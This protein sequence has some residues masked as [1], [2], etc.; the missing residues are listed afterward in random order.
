MACTNALLDASA[1]PWLHGECKGQLLPLH[2]G[3]RLG[4]VSLVKVLLDRCPDLLEAKTALELRPLHYAAEAK[5]HRFEIATLLVEKGADV[6]ASTA[7]GNLPSHYAGAMMDSDV[8]VKEV[9]AMYNLLN[10]HEDRRNRAGWTAMGKMAQGLLKRLSI[11]RDQLPVLQPQQLVELVFSVEEGDAKDFLDELSRK[12]P[13]EQDTEQ[14][15][16]HAFCERLQSE[17]NRFI[18]HPYYR[19]VVSMYFDRNPS[20]NAAC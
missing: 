5:M 14:K 1:D 17:F 11:V 2:E 3:V 18:G 15:L 13:K 12:G 6:A 10:C 20:G 9:I 19:T 16:F 4:K 7:D 8:P